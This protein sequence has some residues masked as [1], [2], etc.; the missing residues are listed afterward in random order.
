LLIALTALTFAQTAP[1]AAPAANSLVIQKAL[2][3]AVDGAGSADVVKVLTGLISSNS[4]N[5]VVGNDTLSGDPAEGHMKHL[6]VEY[7]LSGKKYMVDLSEG[8]T[9]TIPDPKAIP[10]PEGQAAPKSLVISKATFAA[11]D[12]SGSADVAKTLT[13]LV[14]GNR[15]NITVGCNILGGDPAPNHVKTLHVEYILDG[16]KF[17]QDVPEQATLAIPSAD[18][19]PAGAN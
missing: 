19:K 4:L 2:Y 1:A 6:H 16:K 10:L 17:M 14:Y 8:D 15:I 13:G 18:A 12:G 3:S 5:V 11:S 9:L 7:V